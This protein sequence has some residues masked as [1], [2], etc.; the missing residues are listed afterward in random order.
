MTVT[1]IVVQA[2]IGSHR[3]PGKV[4]LPL[5]G[6]TVLAHV[7]ERCLAI[8]GAAVVCCA[9]PEG[10][11]DDPVA[12]EAARCGARVFRGSE[13]DV[14]DR[15]YRAARAFDMDPVMRVTSDC[16]LIDPAVCAD[17]LRLRAATGA[18]YACNNSPPTWPHGLDCEVVTF[19]WLERSAR[20]AT[21]AW[22][23][24]HVTPYVRRHP[25]A[26]RVNLPMP[27]SGAATHRWTLDNERD[28]RFLTNLCARLP[29]GPA[30]WDW[31][32]P[33]AIAGSDPALLAINAG[34]DRYEGLKTSMASS[35]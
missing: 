9:V 2:R 10:S 23:R 1:G 21:R 34:Q 33:L 28:Y 12:E 31:G 7:I 25:D 13:T 22:E 35:G 24:E 11:A 5:R 29:R 20:E 27:G 17:V 16:P 14:L 18:D 15:Y 6:R 32:L 8:E 4:L 26:R 30:A 3:L 19:H